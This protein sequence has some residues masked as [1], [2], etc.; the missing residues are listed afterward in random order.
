MIDI[1]FFYT[2]NKFLLA[3]NSNITFFVTL[4]LA[5]IINQYLLILIGL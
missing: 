4:K 1:F 2:K 5:I 3:K